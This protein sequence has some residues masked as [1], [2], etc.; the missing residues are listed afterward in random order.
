MTET[1]TDISLGVVHGS[2]CPVW[3]LLRGEGDLEHLIP[4][5][6][7]F[8]VLRLVLERHTRPFELLVYNRFSYSP[9]SP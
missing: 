2:F 6:Q 7:H 9:G 1:G 5:P 3:N 4:L 8:P